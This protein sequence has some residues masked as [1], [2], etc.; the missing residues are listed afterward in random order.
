MQKAD[1]ASPVIGEAAGA[2]EPPRLLRIVAVYDAE[3]G[4]VIHVRD[5]VGRPGTVLPSDDE[6]AQDGLTYLKEFAASVEKDPAFQ[7]EIKKKG[8]RLCP[9]EQLKTCVIED[10]GSVSWPFRID[11]KSGRAVNVGEGHVW[12]PLHSQ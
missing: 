9:I 6:L 5:I 11:P 4:Q 2:I 10:V 12:K 3:T 7:E 1:H 8:K